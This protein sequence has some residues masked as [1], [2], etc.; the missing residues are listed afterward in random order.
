[1]NQV[2]IGN[3]TLYHGDCLAVLSELVGP[4]TAITDPPYAINDKPQSTE[5]K[6]I[7]KRVGGSNDWHAQSWW[8]AELDAAWGDAVCRV[9]D[10]VAW[11]GHWRKRDQVEAMMSWPLRTEVVWAKD[12]HVGPP[13][14]VAPRDERIWLFSKN[15]IKG[16]AFETSVWDVPMIP[17]WAHKWH[18]N[19]KPV[20]L[21][22]R[23]VAFLGGATILDPFMGSGTT[24]V[25]CAN[26]GRRF[27][28]IEREQ[29]HFDNA[30]MRIEAAYA[31]GRL[32]GDSRFRAGLVLDG[33]IK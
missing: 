31:Q 19:E 13:C 26:L 2:T 28:G 17:T 18:K 8:D 3:A 4:M 1:M 7:G 24:G 22:E 11:F 29:E 33:R 21:M 9:A 15:G 5:R 14:P 30:C 25:A 6:R 27:I 32:F 23:L 12:C 10:V 20:R 16:E